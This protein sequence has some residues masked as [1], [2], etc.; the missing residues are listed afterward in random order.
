M[1]I[2]KKFNEI[3]GETPF[4][5]FK[6]LNEFFKIVL[7]NILKFSVEIVSQSVTEHCVYFDEYRILCSRSRVGDIY[8][9][10]AIRRSLI[11]FTFVQSLDIEAYRANVD[12]TGIIESTETT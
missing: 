11:F 12:T 5:V 8:L 10:M 9:M 1:I 7:V 2:M 6:R 4:S 3:F